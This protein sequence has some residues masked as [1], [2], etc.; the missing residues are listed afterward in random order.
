MKSTLTIGRTQ[1]VRTSKNNKIIIEIRDENF[2]R[3]VE[4]E[5][6]AEEFMLAITG[7]AFQECE[8]KVY[9]E[10]V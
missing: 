9:S 8:T 4:I 5:I 2:D 3:V 1:S 7:M 10:E 6:G